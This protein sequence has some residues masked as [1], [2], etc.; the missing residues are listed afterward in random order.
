MLCQLHLMN[1]SG[2]VLRSRRTFGNPSVVDLAMLS[3]GNLRVALAQ[4]Q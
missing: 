4:R 3:A 1:V 2:R